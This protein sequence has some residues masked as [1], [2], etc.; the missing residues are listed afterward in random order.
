MTITATASSYL[1]PRLSRSPGIQTGLRDIPPD[2]SE[3]P[4]DLFALLC[5]PTHKAAAFVENWP[6]G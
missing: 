5:A 4:E 3:Y 6:R 1:P 2:L